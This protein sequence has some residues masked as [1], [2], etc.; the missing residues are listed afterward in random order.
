M[1]ICDECRQTG[2]VHSFGIL[3]I[4]LGDREVLANIDLCKGCKP[5]FEK[6]IKSIVRAVQMAR[7]KQ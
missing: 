1:M 7:K 3:L 5:I 6:K 2:S 4:G